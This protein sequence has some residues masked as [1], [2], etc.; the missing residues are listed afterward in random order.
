MAHHPPTHAR[1]RLVAAADDMQ[2][3]LVTLRRGIDAVTARAKERVPAI[4]AL[5]ERLRALVQLQKES[6]KIEHDDDSTLD[7]DAVV[8]VNS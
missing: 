2:P 8:K 7:E 4:D 1:R 3:A 5:G 6:A